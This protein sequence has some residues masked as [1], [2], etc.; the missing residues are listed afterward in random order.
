[1]LG[2]DVPLPHLYRFM[3]FFL[4]GKHQRG[5]SIRYG[6]T[7]QGPRRDNTSLGR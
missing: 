6:D 2:H 4:P 3:A 5:A 7:Q 1:M